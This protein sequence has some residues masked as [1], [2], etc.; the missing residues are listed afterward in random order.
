MTNVTTPSM[1]RQIGSLFDGGAVA[2]LSDRHLIERFVARRDATSETAFAALVAR[3]GPWSWTSAGSSSATAI[4]PKTPSRQCS[5]SWLAGP[6][7]SAIL[8]GSAPG[9]TGLPSALRDGPGPDSLAAVRT[10]KATPR[11]TLAW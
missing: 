11:A 4:T 3:Q 1:V 7:R 8:T 10:K 6:A 5:S 9:S 2:G